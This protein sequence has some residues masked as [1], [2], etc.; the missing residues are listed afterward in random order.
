MC[1]CVCVRV[2]ML[3]ELPLNS[4]DKQESVPSLFKG[5][6]IKKSFNANEDLLLYSRKNQKNL[7]TP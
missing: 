4:R 5:Q 2:C 7:L 3:K 6:S 1:V